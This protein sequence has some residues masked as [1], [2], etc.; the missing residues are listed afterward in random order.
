MFTLLITFLA[1]V[2][3]W[4][5]FLGLLILW[6]IDGKI[7]REA[8]LHA[9][10]AVVLVWLLTLA[11]KN[12]FQIERPYLLNG[13]DVLTLT[14]PLDA[15]FPSTHTAIAFA[16][17]T[18]IYLHDKKNGL[19]F[20]WGAF[21]V[22]VGRILA[23]VHYPFDTIAGAALGILVAWFTGKAHLFKMLK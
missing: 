8:V 16:L 6:V 9:L 13:G 2:L 21:L 20:F 17:A 18:A 11:V 23:N 10:F 7:K 22:A 15:S 5:L 3:I 4:F 14:S 1:S 19:V 12:L